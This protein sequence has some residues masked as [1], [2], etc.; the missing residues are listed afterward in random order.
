MN[1]TLTTAQM[2]EIGG[3]L[4]GSWEEHKKDIKLTPKALYSLIALKKNIEAKLTVIEETLMELALQ[5]GGE[6]QPNGSITI[7]PEKRMEANV[8]FQD[9]GDEIIEI[10]FS[11]IILQD[12]SVVP[13]PIYEALFD[14]IVLEN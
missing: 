9:M 2:R 12:D 1:K 11:P 6:P 8:A 10:D 14:F 5:Y 4:F 7:P 3:Q 13:L